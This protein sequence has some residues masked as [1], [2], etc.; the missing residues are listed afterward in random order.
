[1]CYYINFQLPFRRTEL[2][3][4][5]LDLDLDLVIQPTFDW[6]W[7]DVDEFQRGVASGGIR[8]EWVNE[9]GHAKEEVLARLEKREYPLDSSWLNWRPDSKWTVPM[10]PEGWDVIDESFRRSGSQPDSL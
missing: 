9:I 10:L 5:T 8:L 7:K 1:V 4:D 2:G 6:E 3:F